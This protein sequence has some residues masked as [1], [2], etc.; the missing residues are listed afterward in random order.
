MIT[1]RFRDMFADIYNYAASM[2][3][4]ARAIDGPCMY[5]SP[6]GP[7][8]VG[9]VIS[10]E[11]AAK[12]EGHGFEYSMRHGLMPSLEWQ[13]EDEQFLMCD[14]QFAHDFSI[15]NGDWHG[16]MMIRLDNVKER[17]NG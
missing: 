12:C 8:L 13:N 14:I 10:D 2:T 16:Q 4:P 11:E 5:R 3:A 15:V 1:Q 7:C 6:N 9:F 17:M